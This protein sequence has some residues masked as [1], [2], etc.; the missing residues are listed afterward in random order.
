MNQKNLN[1]LTKIHKNLLNYLKDQK[2]NQIYKKFELCL[3]NESKNF[4]V[5]VS[6]GP[7]SLALAFFAKIYSIKFNLEAKFCVIDHG[8]R[9]ES[10]KEAKI[11]KKKLNEKLINLEILRWKGKKPNK[12]IQAVARNKRYNLLLEQCRKHKIKNILL[13]HH[14]DDLIENFILRLTRGSGLNGL[15]SFSKKTQLNDINLLR[16]LINISKN[17]LIYTSKKVFNFYVEDPSNNKEIYKRTRIRNLIGNFEKEGLDKNKF[18]LTI[19]N[20]QKSNSSNN[21]YVKKNL[22]ENSFF[23]KKNRKLIL[24]SNF[25]KQSE[26]VIFR[27]FATVLNLINKKF[28]QSRGKKIKYVIDKLSENKNIKL[29][30]S[31]CVIQKINQT[32]FITKE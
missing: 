19:N 8:L 15:V 31:G 3:D 25:F 22:I 5:A 20:L 27:S 12:N 14:Y 2:I 16:P 11:V 17:D 4:I 28:Y 21:F 13:G 24:N 6:G 23:L 30:L 26:E 10:Q 29:T 32:V 7:D 18:L 1:A 9:R